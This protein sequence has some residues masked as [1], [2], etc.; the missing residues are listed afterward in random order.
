[1]DVLVFSGRFQGRTVLTEDRVTDRHRQRRNRQTPEA[2]CDGGAMHFDDAIDPSEACKQQ[3]SES[4]RQRSVGAG[5]E[6]AKDSDQG[7][8]R[9]D[10]AKDYFRGPTIYMTT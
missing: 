8:D 7:T 10:I 6:I 1:M 2:P 4:D 5:P 3:Q 9:E